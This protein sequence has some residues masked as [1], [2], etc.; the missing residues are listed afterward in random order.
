MTHTAAA[1]ALACVT[2]A[3]PA[4]ADILTEVARCESGG[5]QFAAGHV[6]MGGG[7][8]RYMGLFQFSPGHVLRAARMGFDLRTATGQWGYA[9][10][11]F[12]EEGL[13]PWEA[14][15]HCW[16]RHR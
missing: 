16:S 7:G 13:R 10:R 6:L 8:G 2:L 1:L 11:L 14:S 9:R 15:K 4:R 5:H 3:A 12:A